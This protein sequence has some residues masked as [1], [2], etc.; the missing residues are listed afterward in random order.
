MRALHDDHQIAFNNV[1]C[2]YNVHRMNLMKIQP[3]PD[4]N[5]MK[6]KIVTL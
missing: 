2:L 1:V 5:Q 4:Q 3:K 6:I